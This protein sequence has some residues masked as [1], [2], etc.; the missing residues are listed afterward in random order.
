MRVQ[1]LV[2]ALIGVF[3]ALVG[4][5]AAEAARRERDQRVAND[6]LRGAAR[7]VSAELGMSAVVADSALTRDTVWL[8]RNL[9]VAAWQA[10]GADLAQAL[11]DDDFAAVVEAATK[12][13]AARSV[14]S[15]AT[16]PGA[17]VRGDEVEFTLEPLARM[18]RHAQDVLAPI[19]YPDSARRSN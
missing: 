10:H 7:M 8:L 9:P 2:A 11:G 3:G 18:C 19:A 14:G 17:G 6:R 13:E 1:A 5:I 16:G 4:V 15:I 12:M